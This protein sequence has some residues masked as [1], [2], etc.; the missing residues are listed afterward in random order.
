MHDFWIGDVVQLIKEDLVGTF[1]GDGKK[2]GVKVKIND[3]IIETDLNN[4]T[5]YTSHKPRQIV[6]KDNYENN[7]EK[8][9]S[10]NG[11]LDLHIEKLAPKL[12][13]SNPIVILERQKKACAY[14]MKQCVE[15]K[16]PLVKIIHGKGEGVLKNIVLSEIAN[17]RDFVLHTETVNNGGGV[18]IMFHHKK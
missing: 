14:F 8:Q 13:N 5:L 11:E 16:V 15:F 18:E 4:I 9:A 1:E 12:I 3:Q 6:F 17:Y 7:I 10:F 2:G